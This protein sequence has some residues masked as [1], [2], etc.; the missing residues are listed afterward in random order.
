MII[1]EVIAALLVLGLA[2]TI[3]YAIVV[4]ILGIVGAIRFVRCDHC[5]RLGTTSIAEPLRSC[6][7][8]RHGRLLH[9]IHD[10]AH[11]QSPGTRGPVRHV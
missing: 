2:V 11:A 9:P 6:V 7:H 1:V 10:W 3:A 4:G 5:G 8:C